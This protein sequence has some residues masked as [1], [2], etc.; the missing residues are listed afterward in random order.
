MS[1]GPPSTRRFGALDRTTPI[2]R[3][4]GFDRGQPIDRFYIERFLRDNAPAI[5]GRVLEIAGDDYTR[6]FGQ[7]VQTIDV[8]SLIAGGPKTTIV[9]DLSRGGELPTDA[10]DCIICTQTLQFI[11]DVR[12]AIRTL[13]RILRPRGVALVTVPGISQISR[14]D[15]DH[16]GDYWRFTQASA[17][18]LFEAMFSQGEV[19]ASAQGNLLAAVG[20]LYG[21]AMQEFTSQELEHRD[22]DYEVLISVRAQKADAARGA[23]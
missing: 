20:L 7:D 6:Q 14:Y 18:S 13:H 10:F 5:R 2:S 9:A 21:L 8:L 1:V 4:W 23:D 12:A 15:M 19:E 11:Y 17:R 22:P 3:V 16:W